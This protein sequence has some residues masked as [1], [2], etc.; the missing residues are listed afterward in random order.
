MKSS[1]LYSVYILEGS[2]S[3][4]VLKNDPEGRD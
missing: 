1:S 3:Y 4:K 2:D